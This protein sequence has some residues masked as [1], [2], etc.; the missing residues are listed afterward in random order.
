MKSV[1]NKDAKIIYSRY[2]YKN[3]SLEVFPTIYVDEYWEYTIDLFNLREDWEWFLKVFNEE[4]ESAEQYM[5]ETNKILIELKEEYL[6]SDVSSKISS[7]HIKKFNFKNICVY[8]ISD[9]EYWKIDLTKASNQFFNYIG[10]VQPNKTYEEVIFGLTNSYLLRTSKV[11][12]T[13]L[14][15]TLES[16]FMSQIY[17]TYDGILYKLIKSKELKDKIKPEHI[18]GRCGDALFISKEVYLSEGD[19]SI[20]D[21]NVHITSTLIKSVKYKD[22]TIKYVDTGSSTLFYKSTYELASIDDYLCIMKAIKN[23]QPNQIDLTVGCEEQIFYIM[24]Y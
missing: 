23:Q 21:V 3:M 16:L 19:Y 6:T 9:G 22:K 8:D 13:Q 14:L 1:T 10:A 11:L 20:N 24:D 5:E 17:D 2:W 12:R 4:F 18:I 15:Y 7:V